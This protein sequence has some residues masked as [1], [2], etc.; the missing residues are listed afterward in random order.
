MNIYAEKALKL[1]KEMEMTHVAIGVKIIHD[2]KDIPEDAFRPFKDK[3]EHY[4]M[5]QIMTMVKEKHITVALAKEDH[6]CWKPLIGLGLVDMEPGTEAWEIALKNNGIPD[7]KMSEQNWKQ[8]PRLERRDDT[9][10]LVGPLDTCK[11]EPDVVLMYCDRNSQARWMIGALKLH[12]S[13][14]FSLTMDYIDSC[15][16]SILPTLKEHKPW[17]TIP[18]PGECHRAGCDEH[19]LIFSVPADIFPQ[20]ADD[21]CMKYG[22]HNSR[23]KN[24][25]G[26]YKMDAVMVPDFPR[27][28][29][30][31][32]LYE[33]WGL[34]SDGVVAWKEADREEVDKSLLNKY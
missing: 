4:A 20:F 18:D 3:G 29:F 10:V 23:L 24:P 28:S 13:D 17:I 21:T 16:W 25:D 19:E 34:K 9:I 33:L 6:W 27:P 8:F 14:Y 2:E 31:N 1:K 32:K 7:R 22:K 12:T 30:Y 5:C 26:T 15:I 11:F